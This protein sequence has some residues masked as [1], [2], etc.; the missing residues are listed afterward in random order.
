MES[1]TD[2]DLQ[3]RNTSLKESEKEFIERLIR[4][5]KQT[6]ISII[7]YTFRDK[8]NKFAGW[9]EKE[10]NLLS[11]RLEHAHMLLTLE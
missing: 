4:H 3:E 1:P 6:N 9:D 10:C 11:K 5:R 8:N 7:E 2:S